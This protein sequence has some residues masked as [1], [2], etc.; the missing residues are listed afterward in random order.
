MK[1]MLMVRISDGADGMM[2]VEYSGILH[3]VKSAATREMQKAK[4]LTKNDPK[5]IYFFI[6]ERD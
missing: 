3:Y 5:I 1:C 6:E 2:T 4:K